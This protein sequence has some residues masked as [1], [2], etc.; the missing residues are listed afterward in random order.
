MT[1]DDITCA[2]HHLDV[3]FFRVFGGR[4]GVIVSL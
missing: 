1:K 2:A 4:K 3:T